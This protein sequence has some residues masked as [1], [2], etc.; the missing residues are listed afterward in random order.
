MEVDAIAAWNT[1][2]E[3]AKAR[4]LELEKAARKVVN[5]DAKPEYNGR[6]SELS[7]HIGKLRDVLGAEIAE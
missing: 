5:Q 4:L 6:Y 3:K 2:A 1:R 7:A